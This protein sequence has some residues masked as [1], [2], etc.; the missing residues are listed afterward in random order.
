MGKS[1]LEYINQNFNFFLVR[2]GQALLRTSVKRLHP[3]TIIAQASTTTLERPLKIYY[4]NST[5]TTPAPSKAETR[6][7]LTT[8]FEFPIVKL[9]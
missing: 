5:N 9:T 4:L 2:K 6:T 1:K 3:I 7:L 8:V